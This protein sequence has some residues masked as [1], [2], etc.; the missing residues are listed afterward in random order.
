MNVE[1]GTSSTL[2]VNARQLAGETHYLIVFT[3]VDTQGV[4]KVIT[5]NTGKTTGPLLLQ[6][7]E[8]DG[9]VAANGD[10]ELA[11]GDWRLEVFTQAS[12][13]NLD[14]ALTLRSIWTEQ[15]TV[16]GEGGEIPD[17]DP[18]VCEDATVTNSDSTYTTTVASGATLVLADVTHTDSDGSSAVRPAMTPFVATLCSTPVESGRSRRYVFAIGQS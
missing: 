9:G 5:T 2:Q 11:A 10:V 15:V 6:F 4:A 17:P 12:L 14:T 16:M 1:R 13:T 3:H 8:V 18:I 7:D